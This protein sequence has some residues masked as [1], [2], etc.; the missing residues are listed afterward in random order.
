M[1]ARL[2]GLPGRA[3]AL[4][5][6]AALAGAYYFLCAYL[7]PSLLFKPTITTGGDTASH[8]YTAHYLLHTLLPQGRVSGWLMGNY[9][10]YPLFLFYFPLPFLLMAALSLAT[11]LAVAFKLGSLAGVFTLPAAVW[12]LLKKLKTPHPGPALGAVFS[13]AFLFMEANSMWGGNIPSTL[14]GEFA[15]GLGLS[16][17]LVF[18]GSFY[19]G[20]HTN[21]RVGLNAALLAL[22]G[23][24]HGYTLVFGVA[25]CSFFLL[26]P[27]GWL[28]RLGYIL[29]V[30]LLALALMGFWILPLLAWMGMNIPYNFVWVMDSWRSVLPAALWPYAAS[31][32]GGA[33]FFLVRAR[34]KDQAVWFLVFLAALAGLFYLAAP[35][36]GLVDIRFVPFGQLVLVVASALV[37]GRLACGLGLKNTAALGL[38]LLSLTYTA[39]H[40]H[41]IANWYAW[42]YEGMETKPLHK[43]LMGL[44]R[45][46]AG[47]FND[48]RV[49]YEHAEK[50]NETGTIRTFENLP[51]LAGRPTLEGLYMQSS[52]SAPFVFY[53]QS[54]ISQ[55]YSSPLTNYNYS[56]FDLA[57]GA[58]HLELFNASQ[59]IAITS[60]AK[61]AARANPAFS[62]QASFGPFTVF[63][64]QRENPGYA[65]TPAFAPVLVVTDDPLGEGFKWFRRGDLAVP[66]VFSRREPTPGETALFA[67]VIRPGQAGGFY[68]RLPRRAVQPNPALAVEVEDQAIIIKNA[69]PGQPVWVRVSHHPRWR[70]S[71]AE[72]VWR[73]SPAFMLVFA[74]AETLRLTFA[75]AWPERLGLAMTLLGLGL[76]FLG[77][78]APGRTGL[79]RAAFNRWA[80]PLA[81]RARPLGGWMIGLLAGSALALVAALLLLGFHQ[82]PTTSY[83]KGL[84]R[85][86]AR[87]FQAAARLFTRALERYPLSPI[88]DQ[89]LHHLALSHF[90]MENHPAARAAWQRFEAEYPES[91]LLPEA[92]Y[93]IGLTYLKEGNKP[94]AGQAF[95]RVRRDFAGGVWAREAAR[96]LR[97]LDP[98]RTA[99]GRAMALFDQ[100]RYLEAAQAFEKAESGETGELAAQAAYF[101]AVSL[102]K[103]GALDSAQAAFTRLLKTYPENAYAAEA[104]F[105][106]GLIAQRQG[107]TEKAREA[108]TQTISRFPGSRW[109]VFAAEKLGQA[110]A[111]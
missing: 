46:L 99:Q 80:A 21:R 87:D 84:K 35:V 27:A 111:N 57:R 34:F 1:R 28:G 32:L 42:N 54:E 96:R 72:K 91:R 3:D 61:E 41:F 78:F 67:A 55:I 98:P 71:G 83:N 15:Y 18:L 77:L 22:V 107:E 92:L 19:Q 93:H 17:L 88:V 7:D 60:Q 95:E 13:L 104:L 86:Q 66:L 59:Y 79:G 64:V 38:V 109:A 65:V 94:Q 56:R 103:A 25:A 11:G 44:A 9:A 30:N 39:H 69:R 73:A 40:E 10:G 101:K 74:E 81:R 14:A 89:T 29:K 16:L 12:Y 23:L 53:L 82:D 102:W 105:H 108:F 47:G 75:P 70:A 90:F 8:Y 85:Y 4:A 5:T 51:L 31:G 26:W 37:L 97:E 50:T 58:A 24:S 110:R 52:P 68:E 2:P 36:L 20:I 76:M 63:G 49:A 33:L 45:F 43:E 62:E 6:L 48:P 106:L 100:G